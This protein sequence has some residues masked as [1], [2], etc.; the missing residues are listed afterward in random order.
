M[1]DV[2]DLLRNHKIMRNGRIRDTVCY[3]QSGLSL[4][5]IYYTSLRNI[6]PLN[7]QTRPIIITDNTKTTGKPM[8]IQLDF[9][10]KVYRLVI[11][12]HVI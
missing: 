7:R 2:N 12:R 11:P 5:K 9:S 6:S 1:R 3:S 8:T 4:K 10:G